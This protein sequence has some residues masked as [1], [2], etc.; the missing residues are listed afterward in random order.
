MGG[1]DANTLTDGNIGVNNVDGK[2]K[3]QL[4]KDVDLSDTGSVT[5]GGIKLANQ[6]IANTKGTSET[7]NYLTGL[8]NKTWNPDTNGYV[9]GR[10]ATEDQ[11]KSVSDVASALH[12]KVAAGNHV[13]VN[14]STDS[15]TGVKTYTVNART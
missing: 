3:V 12:T 11:L 13:T 2:L 6:S 7:G 5:I 9:S 15:S 1:A 14:E 10:A 4:N 8:A